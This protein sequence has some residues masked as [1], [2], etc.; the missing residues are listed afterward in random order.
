MA[1]KQ[2]NGHSFNDFGPCE[3]C[4]MTQEHYEDNGKPVCKGRKASAPRKAR[5]RVIP[6]DDP[7]KGL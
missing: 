2:D 1:A 7:K 5:S 6:A 3:N 4:G